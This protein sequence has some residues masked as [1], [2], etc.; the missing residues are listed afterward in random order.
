MQNVLERKSIK[1]IDFN[2]DL[3]QSFGIY[4]NSSELRLLDYVSS[5]NISCGFHAGDP[6]TI[7]EALLHAKE[8][9]VVVGAHIGF[10]DI[11]GFG[12]RQMEL[13]TEELEALV[14]Y[15]VGAIMTFAKAYSMEVEHVRPHGAMYRQAAENLEFSRTIAR[16]IK[17]C[18]KWLVYYGAT[19]E[20]LAQIGDEENIQVAHEVH[21]EK[22]YDEKGNIDFSARDLENTNIS[23]QR[24]KDLLQNSQVTNNTGSRTVV[25]ADSIHFSNKLSNAKELIIQAKEIIEPLP[26]NYKN[27]QKSGWVD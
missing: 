19:G 23:L 21:L 2:C 14:M 3:A 25:R 11:Q 15:Q 12:Y 6:L 17:K 13:D 7:K 5:V 10:D 22:I 16:A 18:S 4:K 9:N 20:N 8:K 26:Y 1:N 24:L 27:A